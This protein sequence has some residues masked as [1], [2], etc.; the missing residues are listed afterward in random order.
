MSIISCILVISNQAL[1][2]IHCPDFTI[3]LLRGLLFFQAGILFV[4]IQTVYHLHG[5]NWNIHSYLSV[6]SRY[7]FFRALHSLSCLKNSVLYQDLCS[8][9]QF[10]KILISC[11]TLSF[12]EFLHKFLH[13]FRA[14][15]SVIW[16]F[17]LVVPWFC[18][19][20]VVL[21]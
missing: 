8:F 2:F 21:N 4:Q 13:A 10:L 5:S 14:P 18:T 17:E 3:I 16:H 12:P 1:Y 6:L 9:K 11:P 20:E 7:H 15:D 19:A